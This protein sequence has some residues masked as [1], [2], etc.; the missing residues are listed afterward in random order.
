MA[1]DLSHI[2]PDKTAARKSM[3]TLLDYLDFWGKVV[4]MCPGLHLSHNSRKSQFA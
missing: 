2:S 4:K 3:G 1:K